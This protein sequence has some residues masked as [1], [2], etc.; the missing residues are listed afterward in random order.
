VIIN[1]N[2]G[3][4]LAYLAGNAGN[5]ADP[6]P[7]GIIVAAGAQILSPQN[8]PLNAQTDPV[9]PT[10]FGSFNITQTQDPTKPKA[11]KIGKDTNFRGLTIFNNVVYYTKGSGGNGVN[12]LYFVDTTGQ[13]GSGTLQRPLACATNGSGLPSPLAT[14]PAAPIPYNSANL[15][16]L[17]V[18][19]YNMCILKGFPTATKS[20]TVVPVRR[21]V[22]RCEHGL[23][24]G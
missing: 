1:A 19:P 11:D 3:R 18:F 12:T 23:R 16:S 9:L 8:K 10:P 13:S 20:K 17:G 7:D 15:Q 2:N 22:R 4:S 5:G 6:Q 14:L 24:C 21:L